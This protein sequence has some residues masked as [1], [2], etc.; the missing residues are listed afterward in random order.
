MVLSFLISSKKQPRTLV[1]E[2]HSYNGNIVY[3]FVYLKSGISELQVT[4]SFFFF[5]HRLF[6]ERGYWHV[7]IV[8]NVPVNCTVYFYDLV[9]R[10][11]LDL[12]DALAFFLTVDS[13]DN[14]IF[15]N[16]IEL[17][18]VVELERTK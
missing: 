3:L 8:R 4:Y 5:L 17:T 9:I 6:A 1:R 7:S 16:S 11:S 13:L 15:L 12:F 2:F 10:K 14:I 18:N